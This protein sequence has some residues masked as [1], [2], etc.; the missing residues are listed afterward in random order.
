MLEVPRTAKHNSGRMDILVWRASE[1]VESVAVEI[2]TGKSNAV[3]NVKRDLQEE[4]SKV[5]VVATD[6]R[7][8]KKVEK[9]LAEEGLLL[10]GRVEDVLRDEFSI[11]YRHFPDEMC[12]VCTGSRLSR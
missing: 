11:L 1:S 12:S 8:L 9:Q 6:D 3:L 2:E 4:V 10:P 7:A 5:I